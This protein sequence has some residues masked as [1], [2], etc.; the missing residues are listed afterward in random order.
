MIALAFLLGGASFGLT[1]ALALEDRRL[2]IITAPIV[3]IVALAILLSEL[4]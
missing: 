4:P 2:I 3:L 1:A